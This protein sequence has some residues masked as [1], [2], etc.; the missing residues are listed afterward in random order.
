MCV[1]VPDAPVL[2]LNAKTASPRPR[3]RVIFAFH[4][5][6]AVNLKRV[7]SLPLT[8]AVAEGA[9]HQGMMRPL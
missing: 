7:G 5:I 3:V 1:R 4:S 2:P 8:P 9:D 6:I